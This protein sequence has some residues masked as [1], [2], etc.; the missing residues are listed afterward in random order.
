MSRTSRRRIDEI[1]DESRQRILDAA[2]SLFAERGF[3]RTSFA[4]IAERSGIS[5]GSIPWHF[6]NK[7]GLL[8]AVVDRSIDRV[9][10]RDS[11]AP[12]SLSD[13]FSDYVAWA[14][15]G[16]SAL[17][18]MVASEVMRSSGSVREQYQQF[19]DQRQLMI[20]RWLRRQR[21]DGVQDAFAETREAAFAA[22]LSGALLGAHF[23][24]LF[25]QDFARFEAAMLALGAF[26]DRNIAD[27]WSD[28]SAD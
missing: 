13:V 16:D 20:Q 9:L 3:D 22:A 24:T 15:H 10:S 18:F 6:Q 4:E 2:E 19:L 28:A 25:D 17:V 27:I 5:R 7:D 12:P 1:G 23:H 26:V 21:P 8:I 14:R 11:P